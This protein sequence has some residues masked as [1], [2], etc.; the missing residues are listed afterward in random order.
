MYDAETVGIVFFQSEI[1]V[2]LFHGQSID[3]Q[4]SVTAHIAKGIALF[5]QHKYDLA[6]QAFDVALRECDNRDKVLVSLI[7]VSYPSMYIDSL[8]TPL[9][10][11]S[12]VLFEVG[13]YAKGMADVAALIERCPVESLSTCW[14]TQVRV[15]KRMTV[16]FYIVLYLGSDVSSACEVGGREAGL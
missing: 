5:G 15:S 8:I 12:I 7:K 3:I 16:R 11:Q 2:N 13:Y 10:L 4:P 6:I 9:L 1:F 14:T